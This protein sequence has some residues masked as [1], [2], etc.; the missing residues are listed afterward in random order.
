MV[1]L[2]SIP[3]NWKLLKVKQFMK[4]IDLIIAVR[5]EA[6][7]LPTLFK[8]FLELQV[9]GF[10]FGLIF[11]EDGSTDNTIEIL[12]KLSSSDERV[13][14]Y[15]LLNP[16][17]PGFALSF[18]INMSDADAVITMDA[19]GSHPLRVVKLMAQKFLEGYNVVQGHRMVYDRENL[20]RKY[21]SYLFNGTF[22]LLSGVN[23][24]RQN[25]HFRL[26]DRKAADIFINNKRWWYSVRVNFKG[27]QIK[28][29]FLEFTAPERTLGE[30][31]F[32]FYR[33]LK[34][35]VRLTYNLISLRRFILLSML[36]IVI[37]T[38][39]IYKLPLMV[40]VCFII[41]IHFYFYFKFNSDEFN[42]YKILES[43]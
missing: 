19:D 11:I 41:L 28:S 25:V 8:E 30:S 39:L 17:G 7:N 36:L 9:S 34:V 35:A 1:S 13:K 18:G 37:M 14:F 3:V 15:S 10:E 42:H 5:N 23:F 22:S 27:H 38:I 26:M 33:L 24:L 20:F 16:Y 2:K 12:R 6:E 21:F 4:K 40:I 32:N 43:S 31:K 29:I